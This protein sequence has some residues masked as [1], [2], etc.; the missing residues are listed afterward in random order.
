VPWPRR[1]P[2][3]RLL[4]WPPIAELVAWLRAESGP[5]EAVSLSSVPLRERLPGRRDRPRAVGPD[6]P[7]GANSGRD[8]SS[9]VAGARSKRS[10]Q[11]YTQEDRDLLGAI[12]SSLALL[13]G[14]SPPAGSGVFECPT[15][16][17]LYDGNHALS[18]EP[19]TL[20][21]SPCP[22]ARRTVSPGPPSGARRDGKV[23]AATDGALGRRSR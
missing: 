8:P 3:R 11:P 18:S 10:E 20:V 19:A 23:Y 12:A 16:G 14:G 5:G 2:A 6:R 15:C 1:R 22:H 9:G 4:R 7:G 21:R 17:V 13:L